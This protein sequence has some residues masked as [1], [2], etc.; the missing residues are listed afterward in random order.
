MPSA[1]PTRNG[2][3]SPRTACQEQ[4]VAEPDG[5]LSE[6]KAADAGPGFPEANRDESGWIGQPIGRE[7]SAGAA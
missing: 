7:A 1:S 5:A 2:A 4:A 3:T 6:Q